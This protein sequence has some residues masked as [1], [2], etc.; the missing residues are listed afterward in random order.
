MAKC[1]TTPE[2]HGGPDSYTQKSGG[3]P[4]AHRPGETRDDMIAKMYA[5]AG[6]TPPS[7]QG[8]YRGPG[9]ATS[10][11]VPFK[12]NAYKARKRDR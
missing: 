10:Y 1:E 11:Q 8:P 9:Q 2:S 5:S 3:I 7:R 6:M 4:G 12:N